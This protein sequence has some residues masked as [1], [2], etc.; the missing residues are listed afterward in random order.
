[1][2]LLTLLTLSKKHGPKAIHN[3]RVNSALQKKFPK[4]LCMSFFLRTFAADFVG[5]DSAK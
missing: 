3:R 1:M 5:M 2:A 4:N